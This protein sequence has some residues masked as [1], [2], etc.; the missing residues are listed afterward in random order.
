MIT[1]DKV[2]AYLLIGASIVAVYVAYK[3]YRGTGDVADTLKKVI[4]EDL[5]PASD[6]N[7]VYRQ[8]NT[9]DP[10]TGQ[11]SD[12][13]GTRTYDAVSEVGALAYDSTHNTDGTWKFPFTTGY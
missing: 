10:E 8:F 6:K 2:K 7:V 13:L 3:I 9:V 1:S 4:T 5:N 12:S 11:V